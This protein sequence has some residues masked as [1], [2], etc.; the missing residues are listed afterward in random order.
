MTQTKNKE[1]KK[2]KKG[3]RKEKERKKEIYIAVF[4][5]STVVYGIQ[6]SEQ[7]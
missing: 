6:I 2:K 1:R 4:Y 3:R 5:I 7:L